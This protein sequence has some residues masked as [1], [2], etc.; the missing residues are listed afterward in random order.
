MRHRHHWVRPRGGGAAL[1]LAAIGALAG[2]LAGAVASPALASEIAAHRAAYSVELSTVRSGTPIRDVDGEMAFT[3]QDTCDGWVIEQDYRMTFLYSHGVESELTS[4][5][6]T[7][8]STSGDEFSFNTRDSTDGV[9]DQEL[10]G[11]ATVQ[12]GGDGGTA[13]YRLPEPR[14]IDLPPGTL[15]PTAHTRE[16]IRRAEA[17]DRI[18][19]AFLFDGSTPEG[20]TELNAVI[21]SPIDPPVDAA[22]AD[23]LVSGPSW[24]VDLAFYDVA[25]ALPEPRYEMTLHLFDNGVIDEMIVD[26]GDFAIRLELVH[27]EAL[28][29]AC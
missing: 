12:S 21:G 13:S 15:F 27:L 5:Y 11:L 17:G 6:R 20:L 9:V 25:T 1:G 4:S 16:L 7:F 24:R 3:W 29:R 22:D 26:Y 23:P 18:F 14:E 28:E 8:E 10:R 19:P 2:T